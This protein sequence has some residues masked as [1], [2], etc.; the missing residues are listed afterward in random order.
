MIIDEERCEQELLEFA[1]PS[2]NISS[3]K[4]FPA[5]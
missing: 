1:I 5:M 2:L 4:Q 3:F